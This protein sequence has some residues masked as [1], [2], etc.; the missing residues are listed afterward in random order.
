MFDLEFSPKIGVPVAVLVILVVASFF[1]LID[2]QTRMWISLFTSILTFAVILLY[3]GLS[4]E[5]FILS[6]VVAIMAGFL[7]Y[8]ILESVSEAAIL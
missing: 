7:L 5:G 6:G 4:V 3:S 2:P 8:F 1:G